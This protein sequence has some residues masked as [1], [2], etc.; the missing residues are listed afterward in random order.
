MSLEGEICAALVDYMLTRPDLLSGLLGQTASY[1]VEAGDE[2]D[3]TI[4]RGASG[5]CM[6][7][8][9][10]RGYEAERAFPT[11]ARGA[12]RVELVFDVIGAGGVSLSSRGSVGTILQS[13]FADNGAGFFAALTAVESG[14]RLGGSGALSIEGVSREPSPDMRNPRIVATLLV[15]F[16]H[17]FVE[18]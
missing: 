5:R 4:V 16:W 13:M 2:P 18:P 17:S 12:F 10:D 11:S 14:Y 6:V 7:R 3:A 15:Q 1:H 8:V 9:S